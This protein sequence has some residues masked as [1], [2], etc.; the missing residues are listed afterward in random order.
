MKVLLVE[1]EEHKTA[2]LI[3]RLGAAGISSGDLCVAAG[4][5][6]AVLQVIDNTYDLIVLDMALP[7]FSKG[8]LSGGEGGVAQAV[9]G[10]EILRALNATG[11]RCR[12]IVVT[13]YPDIFINGDKIR[14]SSMPKVISAKYGQ[15]I[16]GAILY[17]YNDKAWEKAFDAVV[18]RIK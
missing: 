18:D 15:N 5:R 14:L 10:I 7:T 1:D 13:Q 2:D 16:V 9:G 17:S 12:I 11:K 4:V 8:G 6:E 3:A